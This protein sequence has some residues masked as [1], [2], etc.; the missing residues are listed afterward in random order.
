MREA[1]NAI[2]NGESV[3]VGRKGNYSISVVHADRAHGGIVL[4]RFAPQG[5]P[6]YQ[7]A[8]YFE[9]WFFNVNEQATYA[10]NEDTLGLLE[11]ACACK[12]VIYQV[13]QLAA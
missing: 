11:L 7:T 1:V 9:E 6:P 2:A 10:P 13:Q 4:V 8:Y 12:R 5:Q 3:H